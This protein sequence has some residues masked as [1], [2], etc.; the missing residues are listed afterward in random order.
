MASR[1]SLADYHLYRLP[2]P[3]DLNARQT[4]QAVFLDKRS[5]KVERFYRHFLDAAAY[6]PDEPVV[7]PTLVLGFENRK[8]AGLG[9]PLPEG[10]LRLFEPG[11]NGDLFSGEGS[12]HDTAV[13]VPAEI[14]LAGAIDLGLEISVDESDE[15]DRDGDEIAHVADAEI[16]IAN[17]KGIPVTVEIRQQLG[18]Y[19]ANA[20][21]KRASHST[22]RKFGDF[23]WRVRVPANSADTLTYRLRL[24]KTAESAE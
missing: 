6:Y 23:A 11:A 3:T 17:A 22:I 20:Q 5:V 9:E 4:K 19:S 24:P 12:M 14:P 13:G 2:W 21:I 1:E 18:E 7:A 10:V 15:E 8:S 16:R